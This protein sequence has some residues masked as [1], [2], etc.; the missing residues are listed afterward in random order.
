MKRPDAMPQIVLSAATRLSLLVV[1]VIT[2]GA[3]GLLPP[4]AVPEALNPVLVRYEASGGE[5][6]QGPCGFRAE[7]RRDGTV[8]R[9][10]GMA[11]TVDAQTLARLV[12]QV[13]RAD[14]DAI[15]ARQFVGE[16]PRNF[17]GQEETYTFS[18][19]P[20]PV[21]V[22]SCATAIDPQQDPFRLVGGILFVTGG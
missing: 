7:I 12:E 1:A 22:A 16:C 14:W 13:E 4:A 21:V 18:V 20:E 17:D 2:L 9:S 19:V 15:L 5:C 6:P 3:C 10:D 11:Q 8:V